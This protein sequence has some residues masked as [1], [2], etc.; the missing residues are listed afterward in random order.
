MPAGSIAGERIRALAGGGVPGLAVVV[1]GPEGVRA[2]GAA[3]LADI[4]AHKPAS[5]GWYARGFP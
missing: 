3:G 1:A 5:V 2:A 4:A